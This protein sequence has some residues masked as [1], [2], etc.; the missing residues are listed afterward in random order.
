MSDDA[1]DVLAVSTTV[2]V[3]VTIAEIGLQIRTLG[4]IDRNFLPHIFLY[5]L[6]TLSNEYSLANGHVN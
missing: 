3:K 5:R 4:T 6:S 1:E 2:V